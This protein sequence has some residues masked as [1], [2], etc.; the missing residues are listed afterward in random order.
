MFS[1]ANVVKKPNNTT[2]STK[3]YLDFNTTLLTNSFSL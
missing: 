2:F 1:A 3:N